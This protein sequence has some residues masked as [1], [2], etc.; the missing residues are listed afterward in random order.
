LGP[1]GFVFRGSVRRVWSLGGIARYEFSQARIRP[2]ALLGAGGYSWDRRIV[3]DPP[4]GTVGEPYQQWESDINYFSISLGAGVAL[5]PPGGKLAL[6]AELRGH[7]SV[8][9]GGVGGPR[10]M[11]SLGVG[12]RFR[13]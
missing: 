1:E 13:W 10:S 5:G 8:Q 3:V 12:G 4:A 9:R 11:V 7:Q 6:V 2:Y